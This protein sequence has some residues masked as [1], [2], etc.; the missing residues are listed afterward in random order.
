M[1]FLRSAPVT[2]SWRNTLISLLAGVS[3]L[4][5]GIFCVS[6]GVSAGRVLLSIVFLICA[7]AMFLMA[8][9][10]SYTGDCPCCGTK[11]KRLG[12]LHRC[13]HCLVYG[14][15]S[16]GE[17]RELE[18]DCI[19]KVPIFKARVSKQSRMPGLCS[20]C[21]APAAKVVRLRIIR[22]GFAF[23]LD[24][25]NCGQHSGTADLEA[26]STGK[27]GEEVP[28]LKVASYRFYREF[29]RENGMITP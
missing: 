26:V 3:L 17:Y 18:A 25:P 24:V 10:N 20:G 28:V 2:R 12:G 14:E 6:L 9:S 15:V 5:V 23:D 16:K 11:Q 13:D 1:T 29:L 19:W 27:K 22:T 21:G 7:I 8:V 4:G